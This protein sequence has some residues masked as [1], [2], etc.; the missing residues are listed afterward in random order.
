MGG[1]ANK[2][3]VVKKGSMIEIDGSTGEG[4]GQ[5]LRT[6]LS[7]AC[8]LEK[9]VRISNIRKGRGVPGLRAQHL[10]VCNLLAEITGAK[11]Q[12]ERMGS[13][14][15]IFEPGKIAG[16][17]YRFDIGT[18]G[19]CTLLLQAAL[20]VL[21]HAKKECSLEIT[22][23]THVQHAPTF[24]YFS[25]VFLPAVR[26][27]GVH[28]EARMGRAG[29]YPKGGGKIILKTKHSELKG[30]LLERESCATDYSIIS[31]GIPPHVAEREEKGLKKIFPDAQGKKENSAAASPGN[32]LSV[33]S[34]MHGAS[35]LGEIG[36]PAEKVA[37][38]ACDALFGSLQS[39][40]AVDARLAD[41]LLIYAALAEGK[42][43]FTTPQ[44]TSHLSTNAEILRLMTGRN[45]ILANEREIR[46][47]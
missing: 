7:V 31:S 19:S 35:S 4:G 40:A 11:M 47:E 22:G 33:W 23:G 15:I 37:K 43:A 12:G 30:C 14:E 25:N 5:V 41:Q 10:T 21:A 28:A 3:Q 26:K 16:G 9:D 6:A 38:E 2:K 24:E 32:A 45:I 36:K 29:F 27:F 18:A 39:G 46:V 44:F 42:T 8:V 1:R 17:D 20:P 13:T 34:G